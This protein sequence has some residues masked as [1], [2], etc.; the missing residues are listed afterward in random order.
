MPRLVQAAGTFTLS[1]VSP[2]PGFSH[3]FSHLALTGVERLCPR[4]RRELEVG[5]SSEDS[6]FSKFFSLAVCHMGSSAALQPGL[7]GTSLDSTDDGTFIEN[8]MSKQQCPKLNA[9]KDRVLFS[10]PGFLC[11][12]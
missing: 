10:I 8:L 1:P 6:G 11:L 4:V 9:M 7:L 2:S 5:E 12:F 3:G